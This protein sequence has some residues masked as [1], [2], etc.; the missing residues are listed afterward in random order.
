LN[1][2]RF[3]ARL[4]ALAATATLPRWAYGA[5]AP[6]D[7]FPS[8]PD[9]TPEPAASG[10][11]GSGPVVTLVA[12]GDTVLGYNLEAHFDEMLGLGMTREQLWP[13]Y[14]RGVRPIVEAADIALV[15]LECP[16]TERGEPLKKNFNFRARH[17]LVEVLK[18][19]G[20][21]IV[22]N[23]NNHASDF[24]P[25]GVRD[26]LKTLDR[27]KIARFGAGTNLSRARRPA[28]LKRNGLKIGFLG[29][30]FQADP[31]MIEPEEVYATRKRA[32]VA[33]CYKDLDC[34]RRMVAEDVKKLV[35]RVD[36]VIPYFHWGKEG[37]YEVR[38]YQVELA[39][40]CIDLGARA[41]LGA[42][43]HRIQGVEVY[44]GAPIFYS[45]GNFV[46]GGIKEPSDT[47]TMIARLRIGRDRVEAETIPV[48]FTHWPERAFQPIVLAGPERDEAM[49]R[50]AEVSR[51][52]ASPLPQLRPWLAATSASETAPAGGRR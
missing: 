47:L 21:D 49:R 19:G 17:E 2:R 20:V 25:Q 36:A 11:R 5:T 4:T 48:E 41:V 22:S 52:L 14:F 18:A 39:R 37:S 43:P 30:Y 33:G 32:G 40:L 51:R 10:G 50:I 16:F 15:N 23:A 9:T 44:Q 27:A 7:T 28:I 42:H 3:L 29:H 1:R 12:G 26:T 35:P 13:Y 38:D 8:H 24:G 31:D 34:I 46:Y 6:R 45:L